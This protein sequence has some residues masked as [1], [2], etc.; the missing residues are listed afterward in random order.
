MDLKHRTA[1]E[2]RA[3]MQGFSAGVVYA[4]D[5]FEGTMH[6][7]AKHNEMMQQIHR[8]LDEGEGD[9]TGHTSSPLATIAFELAPHHRTCTSWPEPRERR[10]T[11]SPTS[12]A[13]RCTVCHETVPRDAVEREAAKRGGLVG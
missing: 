9:R 12:G 2:R 13:W 11:Q 1:G 6:V 8:D 10:M 3:Y 4:L 5:R 7:V